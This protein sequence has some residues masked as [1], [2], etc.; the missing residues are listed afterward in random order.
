MD[1][2]SSRREG[3][4][5]LQAA[6]KSLFEKAEDGDIP[7]FREVADR[8]DGKPAQSVDIGNRDGEAFQMI[9]RTIVDPRNTNT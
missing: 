4:T 7:A 6:C 3:L 2:A 9:Q 5:R 8:V 1:E